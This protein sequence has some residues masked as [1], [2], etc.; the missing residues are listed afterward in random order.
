MSKAAV[1]MLVFGIYM[2]IVGLILLMIPNVILTL[3][4][5]P[6]TEEVWIRVLGLIVAIS[7]CYYIVAARHEL[8]DFFEAT[9]YARPSVIVVFTAFVAL[10]MAKPVLILFGAVDLLGAI[11]TGLALRSSRD[12]E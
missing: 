3:F 12:G 9:V 11:W 5:Y 10:D 8:V 4:A 7:G 2:V 1:S 6:T